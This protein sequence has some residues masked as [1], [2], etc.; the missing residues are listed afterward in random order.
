MTSAV[1]GEGISEL[2]G[3][4]DEHRQHLEASGALARGRRSRLLR[5][6]ESLTAERLRGAIRELLDADVSLVDDLA[7]RRIDPYRAA[8]ILMERAPQRP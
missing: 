3:A 6:V 1:E 8:A 2:W 5:E 4:I 7:E